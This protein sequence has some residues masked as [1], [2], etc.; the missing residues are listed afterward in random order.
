VCLSECAALR[1][2]EGGGSSTVEGRYT[3]PHRGIAFSYSSFVIL[4]GNVLIPSLNSFDYFYYPPDVTLNITVILI[5]T[6]SPF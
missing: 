6:Q 3:K 5:N 1:T 4:H 2:T